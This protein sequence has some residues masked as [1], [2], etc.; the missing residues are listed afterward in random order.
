M[1]MRKMEKCKSSLYFPWSHG[2]F[3]LEYLK[4]EIL[5]AVEVYQRKLRVAEE[6]LILEAE[7]D[8]LVKYA[9]EFVTKPGKEWLQ[10]YIAEACD[11]QIMLPQ[12]YNDL[13]I[14]EPELL[15]END[16]DGSG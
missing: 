13:F 15:S 10:L 3:D 7:R 5:A 14:E 11:S 4:P 2:D 16:S 8:R 6:L 9:K 12:D 1:T